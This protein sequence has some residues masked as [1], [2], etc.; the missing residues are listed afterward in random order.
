MLNSQEK[1]FAHLNP[2]YIRNML[3]VG[4]RYACGNPNSIMPVWSNTGNP[5]GPAQLQADRQ[6]DR[7]HPGREDQHLPRPGSRPVRAGHRQGHGQG[8]DV[9]GLGGP[10]LHSRRRAP[11]PT[12]PAGRTSSPRPAA[13]GAPGA[14]GAPAPRVAP[15][16]RPRPAAP[17]LNQAALNIAFGTPALQRSRRRRLPDRR[18]TTRTAASRT[19]SRSRTRTARRVFKGDII[20]GPAKTTYNVPALAAG[21]YTFVCSVH[22]NMTGT[23]KVGG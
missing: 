7:V 2:D 19:T 5:A 9:P 14:S 18:S 12:R 23:L 8:E 4:G 1:L 6:P 21:A 10:G 20:T 15:A 3:Q 13:S 11:R 17:S 22:P 16:P